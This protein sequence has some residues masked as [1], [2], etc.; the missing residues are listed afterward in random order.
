MATNLSKASEVG[1][2]QAV[3]ANNVIISEY[4]A[5]QLK[6]VKKAVLEA[7]RSQE[8]GTNSLYATRCVVDVNTGTVVE[9][10]VACLKSLTHSNK[11]IGVFE[12]LGVI[13]PG[14]N[15]LFGNVRSFMFGVGGKP[16]YEQVMSVNAK[17][18]TNVTLS[19]G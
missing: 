4:N 15:A 2:A 13:A 17:H 5:D 18:F 10:K 8:E 11:V 14:Q 7:S 1:S 12:I 16:G 6:A 3:N 19:G 9:V